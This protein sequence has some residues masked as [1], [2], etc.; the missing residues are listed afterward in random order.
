MVPLRRFTASS[1]GRC[2]AAPFTCAPATTLFGSR[3][4]QVARA[5]ALLSFGTV[6]VTTNCVGSARSQE[7]LAKKLQEISEMK[8]AIEQRE[9]EASQ[10]REDARQLRFEVGSF[11]DGND[12]DMFEDEGD[13]EGAG[14]HGTPSSSPA[15]FLAGARATHELM[16]ECTVLEGPRAEDG[17]V[18]IQWTRKRKGRR[19][20]ASKGIDTFNRWV[21]PSALKLLGDEQP[22]SPP[23]LEE[24]AANTPTP[25]HTAT[26]TASSNISPLLPTGE[27]EQLDALG[28]Q[29]ELASH[30]RARV[31]LSKSPAG[32]RLGSSGHHK[33][34]ASTIS[35]QKR[36]DEF[37]SPADQ[38]LHVACGEV[39]CDGCKK[40]LF[41]KH[42]TIKTHCNSEL[43]KTNMDKWFSR[44]V[45]DRL[46]KEECVAPPLL[47]RRGGR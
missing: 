21:L 6:A 25:T 19:G 29:P 3:P 30:E 40:I 32:Q 2:M 47:V 27:V 23:P 13:S 10:R 1:L 46:I 18:Q 34:K 42:S 39:R 26:A 45:R 16:K 9:H 44:S 41:N 4:A 15:E 37:N 8:R 17:K 28:P 5:A 36:C 20:G 22:P 38:S 7:D 14:E 11:D 12:G 24:A 31:V 43:H 33:S 35:A